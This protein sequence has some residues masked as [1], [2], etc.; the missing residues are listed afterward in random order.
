MITGTVPSMRV[1]LSVTYNLHRKLKSLGAP[2]RL[3]LASIDF[4]Q[5]EKDR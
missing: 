1:I 2:A 5:K 3:D 4:A